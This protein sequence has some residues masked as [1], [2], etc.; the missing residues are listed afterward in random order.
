MGGMEIVKT[1]ATRKTYPREAQIG[2]HCSAEAWKRGLALRANGDTMTL[3][4]PLVISETELDT[5]FLIARDALD[6]TAR[7]FGVME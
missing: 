1:K 7:H 3:M 5:V 2:R 4:P 6:A